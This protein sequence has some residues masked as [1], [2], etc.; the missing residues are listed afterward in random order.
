MRV[1]FTKLGPH[2]LFIQIKHAMY[3][4][5][6]SFID[7]QIIDNPHEYFKLPILK[8]STAL[9]MQVARMHYSSLLSSFFEGRDTFICLVFETD[10]TQHNAVKSGKSAQW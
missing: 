10:N 4:G 1:K 2:I 6:L 3:I 9:G 8:I 7:T 5:F